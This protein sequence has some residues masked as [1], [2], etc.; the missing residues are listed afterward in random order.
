MRENEIKKL[1]FKIERYRKT[2]NN[3]MFDDFYNADLDLILQALSYY[4]SA[5]P[6]DKFKQCETKGRPSDCEE[7]CLDNP[8]DLFEL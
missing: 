6:C 3:N 7:S 2:K 8:M 5:I 4:E 1:R